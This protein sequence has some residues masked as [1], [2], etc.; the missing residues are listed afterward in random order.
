M[1]NKMY[2]SG[3]GMLTHIES[4]GTEPQRQSCPHCQKEYTLLSLTAHIRI[5]SVKIHPPKAVIEI[6]TEK[7]FSTTGRAKRVSTL[8]A[9]SRLK[10]IG[11]ELVTTGE[12][13]NFDPKIH[14]TYKEPPLEIVL[15]EKW[16][17]D[18]ATRGKGTCSAQFCRFSSDTV[19]TLLQHLQQCK[20]IKKAGFYCN[21]CKNLC[22]ETEANAI[23]HV[24]EYHPPGKDF[25]DDSDCNIKTD[26]EQ[27]SNTDDNEELVTELESSKCK[28]KLKKKQ[29][30]SKASSHN[31]SPVILRKKG[32]QQTSQMF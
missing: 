16:S 1:C 17:E 28:S 26:D 4:C 13:A 23:K 20:H 6:P 24:I 30:K 25:S 3:L 31:T 21:L 14:I 10:E 5:C 9:E 15:R 22:Y 27:S 7:V 11:E 12:D 8:K 19:D 32:K 29:I 18:I 2:R